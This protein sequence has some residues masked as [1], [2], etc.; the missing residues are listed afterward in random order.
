MD[1][2]VKWDD[3]LYWTPDIEIA[4]LQ[5]V[6]F[7]FKLWTTEETFAVAELQY[8]HWPRKTF[9]WDVLGYGKEVRCIL[10]WQSQT[11]KLGQKLT[12]YNNFWYTDPWGNL[13]LADYKFAHF[14]WK[15][16]HRT[17]R[18]V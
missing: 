8:L 18:Y 3:S 14:A 13:T 5:S 4:K 11:H 16:C 17:T 7:K 9:V 12:D 10:Q 6:F 15:K 1:Q 2:S